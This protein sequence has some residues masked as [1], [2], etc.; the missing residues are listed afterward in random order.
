[1]MPGGFV[2]NGKESFLKRLEVFQY[3]ILYIHLYTF[4][5]IAYI[6]IYVL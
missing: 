1:M 2:L 5:F 4:I 3:Q 6:H